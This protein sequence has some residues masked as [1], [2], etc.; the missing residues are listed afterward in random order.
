M[1]TVRG[2]LSAHPVKGLAV[3]G[4]IQSEQI[5]QFVL[6]ESAL[7]R[8]SC[9]LH[10]AGELI[11]G[12]LALVHFLLDG[13]GAQEAVDE[14]GATL[15]ISPDTGHDLLIHSRVPVRVEE[16]EARGPH[17]VQPH[18]S[19]VRGQEEEEEIVSWNSTVAPIHQR[20]A[21]LLRCGP[22]ESNVLPSVVVCHSL[23]QVQ[24]CSE[25]GDE[26]NP[27]ARILSPNGCQDLVQTGEL[28][29]RAK[30]LLRLGP[31]GCGARDHA[32][33][34]A[35][36]E[37]GWMV[38]EGSE[39]VDGSERVTAGHCTCVHA[40]TCLVFTQDRLVQLGLP[41]V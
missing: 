17:E 28:G 34:T 35:L 27:L 13:A 24:G 11:L 20:L 15:T 14:N 10:C 32:S 30:E 41:L 8:A 3:A 6:T 37:Q 21:L 2:P 5:P 26:D 12:K 4:C 33:L 36:V 31:G 16:Y 29:T 22:V 19:G 18:A 1:P 38:A 7:A 9:I 25:V 40:D 23:E 39:P